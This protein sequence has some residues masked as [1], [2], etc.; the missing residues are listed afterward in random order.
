MARPPMSFQEVITMTITNTSKKIINIGTSVLMPDESMKVNDAVAGIPAIKAML[1]H[2]QL[3]IK[4]GSK[5][6]GDVG[7]AETESPDEKPGEDDEAETGSPDEKPGE[8]GK[9]KKPLYRM[10][11]A[12]LIE[13]CQRLGIEIGPDY[14]NPTLI[15]KIK[16]ATAE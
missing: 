14:T 6:E 11:K 13:E 3:V 10:S 1:D 2:G 15:E 4:G 16:A 12:E 7:R 8:D 9:E 5:V